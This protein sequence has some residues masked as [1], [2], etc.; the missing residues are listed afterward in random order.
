MR[1]NT[2]LRLL[3]PVSIRELRVLA[4]GKE[5]DCGL[6]RVNHGFWFGRESPSFSLDVPLNEIREQAQQKF[7]NYGE[8]E[9]FF[10]YLTNAETNDMVW[11]VR[12]REEIEGEETV[13]F[14]RTRHFKTTVRRI[15]R[16]LQ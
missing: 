11:Y 5:D 6:H 1:A 10:Y 3:G 15:L 14:I 12:T 13:V 4:E 8:E 7:P 2:A 16:T 9:L